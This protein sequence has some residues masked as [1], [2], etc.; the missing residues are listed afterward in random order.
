MM[1]GYL[2][3][4]LPDSLFG[5]TVLILLI[6]MLVSHAISIWVS[7]DAR[8]RAVRAVGGFAASQRIANLSRL[9]EE[10]PTDWRMR[11]A[12]A[13]SDQTFSVELSSTA[14]DGVGGD[15]R[16]AAATIRD[17]IASQLREWNG[18]QIR[19]SVE[20]PAI[21]SGVLQGGVAHRF[22]PWGGMGPMDGMMHN[23]MGPAFEGGFGAWKSMQAA[24][25]L[26]DGQWLT[27]ATAL[28]QSGPPFSWSFLITF[29]VM[30]IL[31]LIVSAWAVRGVTAPIRTF[32]RAADRLGRDVAAPP[33]EESGALEIRA[34]ARAFNL[35]QSRVRRLVEGRTQMLAA[36]SHDLR[37]PLTLLRLRT[38]DVENSE[39]RE[40]MLATIGEMDAMIES[41]LAFARDEMLSEP[42]RRTD[43]S[44]L[45]ASIVD[46]MADAGM[47][48][49]MAPA[50]PLPVEC[51]PGAIK[52][53]V[54]NLIDNA[55]KYG[56]R[57][58]VSI[59]HAP[60]FTEIAVEDAGL[61]IPADMMEKVFQPFYRIEE[62]RSRETGGV[63]LGLAI[64]QSIA[65]AHGGEI[66]LQ[67]KKGGGLR[68]SLRLP[69]RPVA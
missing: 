63:G 53:V 1:R 47:N 42:R 17:A 38:E 39:E 61:G 25:R 30:G 7:S 35:M 54:S 29:A 44:A 16:G 60:D 34:A 69:G 23:M 19:V 45:V 26:S 40:K 57:A 9:I 48:V 15:E 4:H 58:D 28:P 36:L 52:R 55:V 24:V 10:A 56:G 14:P 49:L 32:A 11:M 50:D 59:V 3:R 18:R 64:S 68:A 6:G 51:Q 43:L 12:Q 31:V 41:T 66:V 5:R 2:K 21:E 8:E 67:N 13:L 65:Q 37:T 46:D 20:N 27:F 33:L 62:S 22:G